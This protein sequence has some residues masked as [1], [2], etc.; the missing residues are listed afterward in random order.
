MAIQFARMRI[1]SRSSGGNVVRSAA[2]NARSHAQS[3]LTGEKFYFSDRD[4]SEHHEVMLPPG[5]PSEMQDFRNLWNQA[6]AAEKRINSQEAKELLLALPSN[7][8]VSAQHRLEIA[9]EFVAINFVDQG[10][11]AQLDIHGPHS[12]S[13]F[14]GDDNYHA[15]ILLTTRR[16]GAMGMGEKARDLNGLFAKGYMM[17]GERW[18]ELWRDFQN[19]YFLKNGL[20]VRVDETSLV[21]GEH[22]GPE[23]MRVE[24][25]VL[26]LQRNK[27]RA[28]LT[29]ELM[30]DPE[31]VLNHL[32]RQRS[33]FTV[34]ELNRYIDQY[35]FDER[36][37][38][39]LFEA[40]IRSNQIL[41]TVDANGE[42]G[43]RFTTVAVRIE[44]T[45]ALKLSQA[46][47]SERD[48]MIKPSQVKDIASGFDLSGEQ[49]KA[50]QAGL[51][52]ERLTLIRGRAGTGKS[53]VLNALRVGLDQSGHDVIGLAPTNMVAGALRR[54]GFTQSSTVHSFL[55]R[56]KQDRISLKEGT[57]LVVDEAAMLDSGTMKELLEAAYRHRAGVVLV[58]D[59]GQLSAIERGGLFRDIAKIAKAV[60]IKEVRRQTEDWSGRATEDLARGDIKTAIKAYDDRGFIIRN[61]TDQA[62]KIALIEKWKVDFDQNRKADRFVFAYRNVDVDQFN[63]A[64]RDHLQQ[65]GEVDRKDHV[66]STKHGRFSFAKGDRIVMTGTDK[67][68]GLINGQSGYVLDIEGKSLVLKLE[69]KKQILDTSSFS[70]F[71]HHYAGTIYKGQG[72]TVDHAYIYHT[73]HWGQ[74]NAYVALSRHRSSAHIFVAGDYNDRNKLAQSLKRYDRKETSL[75][76]ELADKSGPGTAFEM[77]AGFEINADD[78]KDVKVNAVYKGNSVHK[79]N[80]E[81]VNDVFEE[82]QASMIN[83]RRVD[84]RA[85]KLAQLRADVAAA[86]INRSEAALKIAQQRGIGRDVTKHISLARS[87]LNDF[88]NSRRLLVRAAKML[89]G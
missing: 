42:I 23:R 2:Y 49:T 22:I 70:D 73:S 25:D 84:P 68:A 7:P 59:D 65:R 89:L 33:S 43:D 81:A 20:D 13:E 8:E 79:V 14:G 74:T 87:S 18:G 63:M 69:G 21:P 17:E 75:A 55:F 28:K 31:R 41:Y 40:V 58:G 27:E 9:R 60:E 3:D 64:I 71:R 5:A 82:N 83:Y 47:L 76:L 66:F 86:E 62:A 32:T 34:Q 48:E 4:G 37:A 12:H 61:D 54:D 15:H 11:A 80:A 19:D 77:R 72:K 39:N 78:N 53:Y 30:E 29:R 56:E 35:D 44:E 85:Y 88:S 46:L 67:R 26:A 36:T 38:T 10:L 51:S 57:R 24:A 52:G 45:E 6:Q 16:V 50:L 1:I